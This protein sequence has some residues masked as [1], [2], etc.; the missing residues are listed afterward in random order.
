MIDPPR[1]EVKE[2]IAACKTAG[3]QPVMITGDHPN[4]AKTIATQIGMLGKDERVITVIELNA[5]SDEEF[6]NS[7][8]KIRVYARVSPEQKLRI[9]HALQQKDHFVSM[10][11]DGVNDAPSLKAA[12]IGVAMGITGTDVSKEVAQMI[13]LDDNFASIVKGIKEGRRIYDNIRKFVKY[14]MTCNSAEIWTL[15]MAPFLGLPIPL[16]PIHI[17]WINLVTDGIPGLTL[18]NEKS[19]HN[20]M[21]RPPRKTNESLFS[22]GIGY[23]IVWVG[24]FM[25]SITLGVQAWAIS[26]NNENWQTMVFTTLALSQ[27]GHVLSIRREN[28]LILSEGFFSNPSLLIGVTLTFVIQLMVVYLP[29]GNTLL[30]TKPLSINELLICIGAAAIVFQAVE[31]EKLFKKFFFKKA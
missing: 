6:S 27:L 4:T 12:N 14:I 21:S 9:V 28:K 26:T 31:L 22:G 11:G 3:I 7:V 19:E 23:H 15:L 10:T 24:L 2:A 17:L 18:G 5:M 20:I 25:A 16:L 30:K 8:E 1:E 13:L 29:W